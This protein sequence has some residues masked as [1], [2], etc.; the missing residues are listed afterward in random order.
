MPSI[1]SCG[2]MA[3]P[4]DAAFTTWALWSQWDGN[5]VPFVIMQQGGS[6]RAIETNNLPPFHIPR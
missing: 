5:L 2:T 1:S 4:L 6:Y 3:Y